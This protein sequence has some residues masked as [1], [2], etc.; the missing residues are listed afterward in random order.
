MTNRFVGEDPIGFAAGD[1]NLQRYVDNDVA[2]SVDPTGLYKDLAHD[3]TGWAALWRDRKTSKTQLRLDHFNCILR[4]LTAVGDEYSK[5][6]ST[7]SLRNKFPELGLTPDHR[8]HAEFPMEGWPGLKY[9]MQYAYLNYTRAWPLGV[10]V[11]YPLLGL[12][13]EPKNTPVFPGF[14][15]PPDKF[16]GPDQSAL[17][18]LMHEPQHDF[19]SPNTNNFLGAGGHDANGLKYLPLPKGTNLTIENEVRK[20]IRWA[21]NYKVP[22]TKEWQEANKESLRKTGSPLKKV[23][24]WSA[25]L[26]QCEKSKSPKKLPT[27]EEVPNPPAAPKPSLR[28]NYTGWGALWRNRE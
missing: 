3:H 24:L 21:E 17:G 6:E 27:F 16:W 5:S 2:N 8:P 1:T 20:L 13:R 14:S 22:P 23:T 25:I 12:S 18:T 19:G 10:D 28:D 26:E 15:F 4:W 11:N 7:H 9:S